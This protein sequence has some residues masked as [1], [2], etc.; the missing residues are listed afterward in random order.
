MTEKE[1]ATTKLEA[2]PAPPDPRDAIIRELVGVI[3]DV[4][5]ALH[6]PTPGVVDRALY[7]I[8]RSH[9]AKP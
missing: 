6:V 9:H 3:V 1:I 2:V 5:R 7:E 4:C 8:Y